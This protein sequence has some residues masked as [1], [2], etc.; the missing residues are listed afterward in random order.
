MKG[1]DQLKYNNKLHETYAKDL[2]A[3]T[4]DHISPFL[5]FL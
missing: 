3:L 4:S 1:G 5:I 2:R